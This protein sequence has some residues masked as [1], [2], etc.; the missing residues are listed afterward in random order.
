MKWYTSNILYI[1]RKDGEIVGAVNVIKETPSSLVIESAWKGKR[2]V[3]KESCY[4]KFFPTFQEAKA[5][6]LKTMRESLEWKLKDVARLQK[7]I[8]LLEAQTK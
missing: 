7:H 2:T 3:R 6:A 8:G 4:C 5:H 1:D